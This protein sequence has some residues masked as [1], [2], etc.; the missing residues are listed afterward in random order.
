ML[1]AATG[2]CQSRRVYQYPQV[3]LKHRDAS[4]HETTLA[5]AFTLSVF[6]NNPYRSC[7][8]TDLLEVPALPAA[9]FKPKTISVALDSSHR[10][11]TND[12]YSISYE[13]AERRRPPPAGRCHSV[14]S[15]YQYH[16]QDA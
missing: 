10:N 9:L 11:A 7:P 2:P 5:T 4:K 16:F 3:H 14:R 8:G 13:V 1:P 6:A 12:Y 15:S